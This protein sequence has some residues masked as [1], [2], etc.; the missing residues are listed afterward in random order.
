M[1]RLRVLITGAGGQVGRALLASAPKDYEV[2]ATTHAEL[3]IGDSN[4][5]ERLLRQLQPQLVINAAAYTAVDKAE[6]DAS[7]A[8]RVNTAGPENLARSIAGMDARLIHISTDFVFNGRQSTPYRP[9]DA[10]DPLSV[11]GRNK[12]DG[13][14]AARET[15]GRYAVVVRT[16]RVYAAQGQNFVRT[17]LRLMHERGAVR[18]VADQAARPRP[19]VHSPRLCGVLRTGLSCQASITTPMRA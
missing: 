15:L 1:S 4:Q 12:L 9:S 19:R 5:V 13:E 18:V 6:S 7:T 14:T 16:A 17:M 3:D 11:Y 8:V 2:R 10:V